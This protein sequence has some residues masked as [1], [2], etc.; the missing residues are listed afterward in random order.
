MT[1]TVYDPKQPLI[2]GSAFVFPAVLFQR[3]NSQLIQTSVT[4]AI[5]D[6]KI[7]LDGGGYANI[8]TL[9]T[10]I[11]TTGELI[12]TLSG[13]ETTG[14]L[15][16]ISVKFVDAAGAE[17][18][19]VVYVID[20]DE[21]KTV[22]DYAGGD[23]S[24]VTTILADYA[25]RTGD[26]ATVTALSTLQGNVT[27]ILADYAR[28]TGDYATVGAAMTLASD[29]ITAAVIATDA[30]GALE[31]SAGASAEIAAAIWAY[32]T[33]SLTSTA[34]AVAAAMSGSD[35]SVTN[36][37]SFSATI[38]GLTIPATWTKIYLTAKRSLE[39]DADA[40]SMLMLMETNP[41]N[42]ADGILYINRAAASTAQQAYGSLT[43]DQAA[44]TIVVALDD[45]L[46]F[47]SMLG[48]YTYD[49]KCLKADGTSVKLA[50]SANVEFVMTESRAVT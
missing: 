41:A 28:R 23:T 4:L 12:V 18:C 21:A 40:L 29:A 37:V 11:G 15:K 46:D 35:L 2:A 47:S 26:Y 30:L 17:W 43:V 5:G 31:L 27:T 7:S 33:R 48:R 13:A 25:R 38:S 8:G 36:G 45:A 16:Y 22:S 6:V 44:G 24:G 1:T 34:A 39:N 9:P 14:A 49:I 42:V 32:A 50:S 10:E 3:A 19:D 20:V